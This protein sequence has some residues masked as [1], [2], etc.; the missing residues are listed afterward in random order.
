[1]PAT[2]SERGY[3]AR[4][5]AERARWRPIVDRG[6]AWCAEVVC[7]L[8]SRWI[9]P[10]TPW[11]LA[12]DRNTGGYLGPAH[13]RCNRAEGARFR[14]RR[15]KHT[16]QPAATRRWVLRGEGGSEVQPPRAM[17]PQSSSFLSPM[18]S[19]APLSR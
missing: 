19:L 1:M 17:T 2:T 13:R 5:Q 8:A 14:N 15:G 4:H 11:D 10:G 12:H 18:A 7:L 3:G 16:A 9:R 6:D